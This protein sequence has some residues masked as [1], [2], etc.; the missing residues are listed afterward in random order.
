MQKLQYQTMHELEQ[1]IA[2]LKEIIAHKDRQLAQ[3]SEK[4]AYK[5]RQ[6]SQKN[7]KLAHK[8]KKLARNA[9]KLSHKDRQL[10][11]MGKKLTRQGEMYD[12]IIQ[13]KD[14]ELSKEY[15]L[16]KHRPAN[17]DSS[18]GVDLHRIEIL[19]DI[20][21]D[22]SKLYAVTMQTRENFQHILEHALVYVES[23]DVR[24]FC[25][26]RTRKSEPGNRCKLSLRHALLMVLKEKRDN[27]EQEILKVDFGVD[28][29]NIS[30]YIKCVNE[31]LK[32]TL[33]TGKNIAREIAACETKEE[34]K[35]IVPGCNGGEFTIDGTHSPA[36][37]PTE[38]TLRRMRYSG[39][40][41]R[42][43]N[44]TTVIINKD[45]VIVGVS[46]SAVG[47]TSDITLL[48][49][50]PM[51]FGKW[52]ELM[53]DISTPNDDRIMIWVDKGYQGIGKDFPGS[54]I[55]IPHKRTK[56]RKLT[57]E[58][59]QHNHIVNRTRVLVE[60]TIGRLKRHDKISDPYDGTLKEYN[61]DFDIISGL[62]NLKLLWGKIDHAPPTPGKWETVIDW[63]KDSS[64]NTAPLQS[65]S[66]A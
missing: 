17:W 33:P 35:K 48:R 27:T 64:A 25:E 42:F 39:K 47:S 12:N 37:R 19:D 5:D 53:K 49:E 51:P 41:K 54:D 7:E 13:K 9:E 56:N 22:D 26:D 14:S 8:D 6:L 32:A 16:W 36:Q 21:S 63:D 52:T 15:S 58:Q 11:R 4:L 60:H 3:K 10:A 29:S 44:N 45:G 55:M 38:K 2:N 61:D 43:T 50:S 62:V 28:Q 34:F 24:L 40:K 18:K 65:N 59:K 23:N 46:D 20:L 31:I 66:Q 30:R 57:T 1:E